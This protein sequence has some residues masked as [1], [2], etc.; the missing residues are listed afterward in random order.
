VTRKAWK[1]DRDRYECHLKP[2]FGRKALDTITVMDVQRIVVDLRKTGKSP[3]TIRN[4]VELFKRVVNYA[5]RLGLYDG[6]NPANRATLPKVSGERGR[7]LEPGQV[8]KLWE[9][10]QEYSDRVS[11][12][13]IL[14]ALLTGCRR[15]ELFRLKW[16]DVDFRGGW[17]TLRDPKG[18]R[19]QVIPLNQSAIEL[20]QDHPKV[21][22]SPYVFPGVNGGARRDIRRP[23]A[24]MKEKVG[25]PSGFRL[26]DLRHSY[27]SLLASSGQVPLH[28][29]QRLLT[30]ASPVMTQRYSHLAE[31]SLKRGAETMDKIIAE[32]LSG[33]GVDVKTAS[34]E[35]NEN[36]LG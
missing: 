36:D 31:E 9:V 1:K 29:V 22:G 2:R 11:A 6:E 14:L 25:L 18:G 24:A 33:P 3:K 21:D 32:A 30:H 19:D 4:V 35:S 17:I 27:A 15:G 8:K 34:G 26:H 10:C 5:R 20:L 7:F 12:N 28:L 13:F 23:W 16:E